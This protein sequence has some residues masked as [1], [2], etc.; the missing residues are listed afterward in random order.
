MSNATAVAPERATKAPPRAKEAPAPAPANQ[1]VSSSLSP[2]LIVLSLRPEGS[3]FNGDR[4]QRAQ[5]AGFDWLKKVHLIGMSDPDTG[6]EIARHVVHGGHEAFG[7][8]KEIQIHI[9]PETCARAW[10]VGK[11]LM[12]RLGKYAVLIGARV[13]DGLGQ[14]LNDEAILAI[15]N[16]IDAV[17]DRRLDEERLARTVTLPNG[18]QRELSELSFAYT[19][20]R[21]AGSKKRDYRSV[22][23]DA[24]S[25]PYYQGRELGMRMAGEVVKFYGK[26]QTQHLD[27]LG[28]MKEAMSQD[29]IHYDK[30]TKANVASGFLE[31]LSTLIRVGAQYLN[32]M[33]LDEQIK[34]QGVHHERWLIDCEE[35]KAEFVTRMKAAR[36]A[37]RPKGGNA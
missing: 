16:H 20:I 6:G 29:G 32:P 14:P 33:W 35:R 27:I 23:F 17:M 34:L 12:E 36:E 26:H 18:E 24:P 7:V 1:Q 5:E 19:V 13:C 15:S 3:K 25:L 4:V 10:R 31:V 2:S 37:K 8:L 11:L 22:R 28:I 9:D 21:E 30:A